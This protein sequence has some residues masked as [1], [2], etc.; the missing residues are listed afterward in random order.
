MILPLTAIKKLSSALLI[1]VSMPNDVTATLEVAPMETT[2]HLT[3]LIRFM[4]T[5]IGI[6]ILVLVISLITKY[7]IAAGKEQ[8]LIR[9]ELG[10]LAEEI[11]QNKQK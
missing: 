2:T 3:M 6:L 1:A 9:I 8:K 10:K 11:K 7:L 4:P 5:L